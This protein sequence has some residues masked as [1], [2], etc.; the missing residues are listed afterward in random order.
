M[1]VINHAS[2]M[3]SFPFAPGRLIRLG[4]DGLL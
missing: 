3:E 1:G 4:I 2:A